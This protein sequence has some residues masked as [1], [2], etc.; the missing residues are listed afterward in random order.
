LL[1][2]EK[3]PALVA[4]YEDFKTEYWDL[5]LS[6]VEAV[7]RTRDDFERSMISAIKT[8]AAELS[9]ERGTETLMS[10]VR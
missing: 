4:V 8:K 2:A 3:G 9:I 7:L 5:Q 10:R 6:W 1:E